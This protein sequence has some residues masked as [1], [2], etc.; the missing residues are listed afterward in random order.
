MNLMKPFKVMRFCGLVAGA[1]ASIWALSAL[2]D[3]EIAPRSLPL[4]CSM[5]SISSRCK[6]DSSTA[7]QATSS[8]S[9]QQWA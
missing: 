6:A 4:I 5:S 3:T 8:R 7:A 2:A 1:A 9:P